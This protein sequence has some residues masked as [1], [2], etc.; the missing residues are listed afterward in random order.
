MMPGQKV[1]GAV[2]Y[3]NAK[4]LLVET[5]GNDSQAATGF[6][7]LGRLQIQGHQVDPTGPEIGDCIAHSLILKD[8]V[9][10]QKASFDQLGVGPTAVDRSPLNAQTL[11]TYFV[12]VIAG[13]ECVGAN[14]IGIS[15]VNELA[16][17]ISDRDGGDGSVDLVD[18]ERIAEAVEGHIPQFHFQAQSLS[19]FV[20]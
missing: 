17:L 10:R 3:G 4:V 7:D 8:V 19:D 1:M 2:G 11:T 13:Q 20:Y 6:G 14:E 16:P 15:K 18:L 12:Q 9:V 5:L